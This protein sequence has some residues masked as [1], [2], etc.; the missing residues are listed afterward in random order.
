MLPISLTNVPQKW[1]GR[2]PRHKRVV[3][4][5]PGRHHLP[6]RLVC[7]N[8]GER[9]NGMQ[10]RPHMPEWHHFLLREECLCTMPASCM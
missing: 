1:P 3:L 4:I 2:A 8:H 6:D 7:V 5:D 10:D 9:A